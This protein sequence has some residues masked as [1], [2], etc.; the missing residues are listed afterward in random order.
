MFSVL[1]YKLCAANIMIFLLYWTINN[2]LFVN[3]NLMS[4]LF[5]DLS[6]NL[7]INYTIFA[8]KFTKT[9]N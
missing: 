9:I 7:A 5:K 2:L 4:I 8:P 6:I 3:Y 1:L